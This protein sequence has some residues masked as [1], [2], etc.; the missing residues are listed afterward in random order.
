ML[1][2]T[3]F[4]K[5]EYYDLLV[6]VFFKK[7]PANATVSFT[8]DYTPQWLCVRGSRHVINMRTKINK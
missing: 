4:I 8:R 3:E 7:S 2:I 5:L 6:L 1:Q